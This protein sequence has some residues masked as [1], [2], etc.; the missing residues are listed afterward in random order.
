[1]FLKDYMDTFVN[2]YPM[3]MPGHKNNYD[4]FSKNILNYDLTEFGELDNLQNPTGVIKNSLQRISKLFC[5]SQSFILVNGSTIGILTALLYLG[6]CEILVN[7][8]AHK[9]FFSGIFLTDATV[10]YVYPLINEFGIP[11]DIKPEVIEKKLKENSKISAV[12]LTSP[13][14]EGYNLDLES[15]SLVCKKYGCILIVD[16]AHGAHFP[17]SNNFPKTAIESGCDIAINSLHKTLPALTQCAIL[18]IN[19]S[20]DGEKIKFLLNTLQTTSPSYIFMYA[21][22]KLME[23]LSLKKL[24]F[25]TFSATLIDYRKSFKDFEKVK[26]YD[27]CR[28][29]ISRFTFYSSSFSGKYMADFLLKNNIQVEM[30]GVN[31]IVC[32]ITIADTKESLVLLYKTIEKLNNMIY[33]NNEVMFYDYPTLPSLKSVASY[34]EIFLEDKVSINYKNSLNKISGDFIIPYPPGIPIITPG[35]LIDEHAINCIT[36]F[37]ENNIEILGLYNNKIKI[38]R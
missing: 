36:S 12:F 27:D 8:N 28:V 38:R 31:Y 4:F 5:T 22:D 11:T 10:N 3:H 7:R 14:Y 24:D 26:L 13:T 19:N 9:S 15:I 2:N 20:I 33:N 32:I 23:D 34:K 37:L 17:F 35:E 1:M 29:D 21:I 25:F 6:K 16:E 30:W 18:H